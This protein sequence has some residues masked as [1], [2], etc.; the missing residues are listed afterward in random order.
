MNDRNKYSLSVAQYWMQ[1][2]PPHPVRDLIGSW[3]DHFGD[4]HFLFDDESATEFISSNFNGE[5]L[6]AY[7]TCNIPAMRADYFRYCFLYLNGGI[8]VDADVGFLREGFSVDFG[9][10]GLLFVRNGNIANDFM[11]VV[12]ERDPLIDRILSIATSNILSKSGTN[13]WAVTGPGIATNLKKED[14]ALF[15]DFNIVP[16]DKVSEYVRF[17]GGLDY[18]QTPVHWL[19]RKDLFR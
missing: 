17:V 1:G 12:H 8:Y 18:K 7:Q 9:P 15:S 10:R 19:N 13:V 5:V 14:S 16:I 6:T 3:R 4:R 2:E 11:A